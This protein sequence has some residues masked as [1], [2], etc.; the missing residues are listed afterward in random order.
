MEGLWY[1]M[2]KIA[3]IGKDSFIGSHFFDFLSNKNEFELVATN[4]KIL[5]ITIKSQIN[6]FIYKNKPENVILFAGCK[7]VK[8]LEQNKD[9]AHKI[10]VEPV[11]NFIEAI[12][13]YSPTTHFF[14]MSS[15]Y[16]FD[17]KKGKYTTKDKTCPTTVYGQN[18]IDVEDLLKNSGINY[19]VIR[20][21]AVMGKNSV[22]FEWLLSQLRTQ[23]S[24]EMFSQSYFTPTCV[25]FLCNAMYEIIKQHKFI[26]GFIH[27]VQEQRLS[28]YE[29]ALIIKKLI[30]SP[31]EIIPFENK[32]KD[33]SLV[34]SDFVKN[35][36]LVDF[37][38]S[39]KE[40]L[41]YV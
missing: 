10:N 40:E 5:D 2:T 7:D 15:D 13:E 8:K 27:V 18:K 22:F 21:A 24:V 38:L 1:L 3:I 35:L 41:K 26:K 6:D 19:T 14:Y 12:K 25:G 33:L 16:V 39:L 34:Q 29:F 4:S 17:G 23:Q 20:T 28:R 11:I 31:C 36:N 32:F 9:W 37:E 30:N